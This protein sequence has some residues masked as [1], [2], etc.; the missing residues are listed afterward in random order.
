LEAAAP[1]LLISRSAR[2]F[3][4][5]ASRWVRTAVTVVIG[6]VSTPILLRLLGPERFGAVRMVEQCFAYL[7]FLGFGLAAA[8]GVLL[9]R[10]ATSGTAADVSAFAETGIRLLFRQFLWILPAALGLVV[11]FPIFFGLPANL[12]AE[13]YWGAPAILLW[14]SMSP[15]NVFRLVLEARQRG[16][17]VDIGLLA[18]SVVLAGI[19]IGFAAAG[20][21]LTGQLWTIALGAITFYFVC[22][23]WAGATNPQFW[24]VQAAA[25]PG[26]EVWR[27]QW[28]LLI[29]GIGNQINLLSDNLLAGALLGVAQVTA[30]LLT[31]RLFQLCNVVASSLNGGGMWAG[32]VDLR[33]R[34]GLKAFGERL[35]DV[36][37][38]NLGIILLVL[39][40]MLACNRRF[41]GLWVGER[42]YA[43]DLVT[44]AT[45]IQLAVFNFL[46]LYA[47][48]IDSLGQTRK[49]IWVSTAGTAL[50]V[51]LLVPLTQWFGLG[52]LLLATTV[53]YLCTDAWFCP[54]VLIR[55]YGVSGQA[56][57]AGVGRAVAVG[58]GWAGVCYLVGIR[59]NYL[60]PGW[61]GLFSEAVALEACG[62]A[63][64]WLLLL[65]SADRAGW[66]ARVRRWFD[67]T[68]PAKACEVSA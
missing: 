12:R 6:L 22:T 65:S 45:F 8:V 34:V 30:L 58:G 2:L 57:L 31:Q 64:G 11:V 27:L 4:T 26:T 68:S 18:Q 67:W 52:G 38:L 33:A 5:I 61:G 32:L 46:C 7:E 16:Y 47:A 20:F 66:L 13:F 49:R 3:A 59:T 53:G 29:A 28:P 51:A 42:L 43:G 15:M 10:A 25:I 24:S 54:C 35:V 63:I 60:L 9:I 39:A 1:A 55:E 23:F 50:K 36:S 48:L 19:G 62:L 56:I 21:G 37:K 17:L 44:L 14:I 41:V 40:P